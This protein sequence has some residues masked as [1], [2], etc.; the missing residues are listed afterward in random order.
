PRYLIAKGRTGEARE[1]LTKTLGADGVQDR[2]ADITRSL[3][4]QSTRGF[5]TLLTSSGTRLQRIVWVGIGLTAL[6]Q[7]VGINAIF[8]Y[9]TSIIASLAL[10]AQASL[11]KTQILTSVKSAAIVAGMLII[12]RVGRSP[13]LLFG[14]ISMFGALVVTAF[15]MLSAPQA[16][17]NPD[18]AG[19]PG[20]AV[21]ALVALC[22]YVFAYAGTWGPIMWVLV[23]EMF[24]NRIRGAA[25]SVAG[26]VEWA[27]NF[28]VTLTFPVLATWSIGTTY[29]IY[30]T[31]ALLS[32]I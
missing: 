25:T 3:T 24:P 11:K 2:I 22:L 21:V 8:Y 23:G 6:Q 9:S 17:G 27:S 28:A 14:S 26:G 13:L 16:N 29:G 32:I 19:S 5:R 20:L 18:L 10:G 15:T 4:A 7:L 30:A 1:V 31:M 12:D